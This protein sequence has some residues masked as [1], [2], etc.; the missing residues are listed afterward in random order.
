MHPAQGDELNGS[1]K[2]R[3]EDPVCS[4]VARNKQPASGA[5]QQ[6]GQAALPN[7]QLLGGLDGEWESLPRAPG[8]TW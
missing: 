8:W 4:M 5:W 6:A 1:R 2:A 7:S 3:E